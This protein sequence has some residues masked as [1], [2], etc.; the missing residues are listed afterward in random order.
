[1]SEIAEEMGIGAEEVAG[2][3]EA[4][5]VIS[6]IASIDDENFAEKSL[7]PAAIG[8]ESEKAEFIDLRNCI[9]RL[10]ERDRSI[11][12][13]RYFKDMTQ[14]Q[15]GRALGISQVQVSRTEKR[16]LAEMRNS[17]DMDEA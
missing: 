8:G 7:L 9:E 11:I 13:M 1:M 4:G 3:M 14:K 2:I 6:G 16:I 5:N 10:E 15:T 12:I 17:L